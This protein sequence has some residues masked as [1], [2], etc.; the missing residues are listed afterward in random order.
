MKSKNRG[1]LLV[2]IVLLAL[3]SSLAVPAQDRPDEI[4]IRVD[5]LSCPFCAYGLEKKLKRLAGAEKVE[6]DIEAGVARIR[7]RE[8]QRI[9]EKALK[10]AVEAAGFT[11][12]EITYGSEGR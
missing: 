10:K 11:P 7:L 5:G 4:A 2:M 9:D 8:G 12:R 6:I 3:A 1:G